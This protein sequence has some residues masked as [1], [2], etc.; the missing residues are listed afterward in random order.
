MSAYAHT[1]GDDCKDWQ[2]L[3]D[4]LLGTAELARGFENRVNG[5]ESTSIEPNIA[6]IA[7]LLH[8]IGKYST[9]FQT[10]LHGNS[11]GKVNH[12]SAGA[13][14]AVKTFGDGGIGRILSYAITG[15]H[16]G[17]LDYGSEISGV[18]SRLKEGVIPDF[19]NY[20]KE[21]NLPSSII[22]MTQ[23]EPT[24]GYDGFFRAFYIKMIFSCLVDADRLDTEK[25][26]DA[27]KAIVREQLVPPLTEMNIMFNEYMIKHFKD[28]QPS[29]NNLGEVRK[30]ILNSCI[31][32][33]KGPR[34]LYKLTVP[35]G[36]GKTLSSMAF[37]LNHAVNNGLE[38]IIYAIPYTSIIEQNSQVFRNIFG[39]SQVLEHHSNFDFDDEDGASRLKLASE[40]WD[41]PL[42]VTTNVQFFESLFSNSASRSRKVHNM[43]NSV[44]ILDEA[45]MIPPERLRPCMAALCELVKNYNSTVVICTAT[46]PTIDFLFYD[47]ISPVQLVDDYQRIYNEMRRVDFV[48]L[49]M[50]SNQDIAGMIRE[51]EKVMCIVN[52]RSHARD[53][54]NDLRDED[55]YHLSANMYPA[56]RKKVI[57]EIR[58]ALKGEGKCRVISTQLIE[59]GVDIDFPVVI[60]A[61]AGLDSIT[62]AAGRC[63]REG[64]LE[65][66][67]LFIFKPQRDYHPPHSIKRSIDV[68]EMA[69][70]S[71][72]GL[73]HPLSNR[74]MDEYYSILYGNRNRTG[75][76]ELDLGNHLA[77]MPTFEKNYRTMDFDFETISERFKFIHD[78]EKTIIVECE[79]SSNTIEQL[80][81]SER[82]R[83]LFRKLQQFTV[84][85]PQKVYNDLMK[86]GSIE[87]MDEGVDI[88]IDENAYSDRFG[89]VVKDKEL[90]TLLF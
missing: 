14:L 74:A 69:L 83:D 12:S 64:V 67:R 81:S 44:I 29:N 17:L 48:D 90:A 47:G 46:Q 60:R 82:R 27:R 41:M 32:K 38:R 21:I 34:G 45:Q 49:G 19:S 54:C 25:F 87:T 55:V 51:H 39:E 63:N 10:Y 1:K 59:A 65:K 66:G 62:Q 22:Q 50:K 70:R 26:S 18:R 68:T 4:H 77:I 89:V 13:V 3:F 7:G 35:T 71:I 30:H 86:N 72:E 75:Y 58:S 31:K 23:K 16:G 53:L 80:R 9:E 33:S 8:D 11:R 52:T 57:D 20:K 43:A 36:C 84:S 6:Y 56:H 61:M 2:L 42:I 85:V 15:H 37:A 76:V 78:Y 24:K 73:D 40:N 88:L 5:R 79:E 28:R